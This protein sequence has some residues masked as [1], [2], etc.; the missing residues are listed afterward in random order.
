LAG[1]PALLGY[2]RAGGFPRQMALEPGG[3][4]LLVTNFSSQ[5]IEVVGVA[6]LP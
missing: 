6:G 1:K 3:R 4:T 5:Q 2:L